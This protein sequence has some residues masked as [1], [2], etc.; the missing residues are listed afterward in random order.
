MNTRLIF[1][2]LLIGVFF[3]IIAII[4]VYIYNFKSNGLSKDPE[5]WGQFGDYI[6]GTINATLSIINF[7]GLT[8]LTLRIVEIEENRNR[9]TLEELARPLPNFSFNVA[10]N[11]I[12]ISL[13]NVGLGPLIIRE[14]KIVNKE[15]IV[16]DNFRDI[17]D[18]ITISY[19]PTFLVTKIKDKSIIKKDGKL[20]IFNMAFEENEEGTSLKNK[21][22]SLNKIK[23]E[24]NNYKIILR[25]C[26]IYGNEME[27]VEEDLE[28]INI[29]CN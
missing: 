19:R 18:N 4:I 5:N 24:L 28:G 17:I 6:G 1:R 7:L 12:K 8:Y 27:I 23:N 25:Y 22:E 11:K 14:L 2:R 13:L 15:N 21:I 9:S 16:Y 10:N 26:D 29:N 3:V 20:T